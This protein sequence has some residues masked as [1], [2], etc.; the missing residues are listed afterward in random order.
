MTRPEAQR[1]EARV[2][3]ER[4]S[5]AALVDTT[6]RPKPPTSLGPA[7][8]RSSHAVSAMV[9]IV[10]QVNLLLPRRRR[11]W[12]P[13]PPHPSTGSAQLH[14]IGLQAPGPEVARSPGPIR[15]V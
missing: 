3:G 5:G 11:P 6:S 10:N 14:R 13:Y 12:P 7:R 4:S 8:R 15:K 9:L 2:P 1:S